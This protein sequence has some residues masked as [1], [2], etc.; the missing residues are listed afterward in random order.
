MD[1]PGGWQIIG[2]TPFK[3]FDPHDQ[4]VVFLHPGE[5]VQFSEISL[6]EFHH[7]NN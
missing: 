7:L 1:T 4:E 2:R 3:I 5:K 6:E